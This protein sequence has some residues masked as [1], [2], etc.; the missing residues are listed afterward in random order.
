MS[1]LAKIIKKRLDFSDYF[2]KL[3]GFL[4]FTIFKATIAQ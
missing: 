2:Y 3:C 4:C 1:D